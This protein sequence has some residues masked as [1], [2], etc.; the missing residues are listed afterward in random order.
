MRFGSSVGGIA[1]AM[2]ALPRAVT[3]DTATRQSADGSA[4]LGRPSGRAVADGPK[5]SPICSHIEGLCRWRMDSELVVAQVR[6]WL[7]S[8][9]FGTMEIAGNPAQLKARACRR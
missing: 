9:C 4:S 1:G 8:K 3:A 2:S 5:V 6:T 7:P